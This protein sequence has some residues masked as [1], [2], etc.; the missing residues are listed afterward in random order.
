MSRAREP[1]I[2]PAVNRTSGE[3]AVM[4]SAGGLRVPLRF[5]YPDNSPASLLAWYRRTETCPD[6]RHAW[7]ALMARAPAD[8]ETA[9][10]LGPD[11]Y[12][13]WFRFRLNLTCTR[14]GVVERLAGYLDDRATKGGKVDPVPI[15]AGALRAQ[16]IEDEGH[17]LPRCT[18]HE[19]LDPVPIGVISAAVTQRGRHYFAGRLDAWPQG[20]VVEAP[21]ITGCLRKLAAEPAMASTAGWSP[22]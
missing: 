15:R 17:V 5:A 3:A 11:E 14:C 1:M 2:L 20:R 6:G 19:G 9:S 10:V 13:E 12:P 22:S 8:A 16:N 7:D 18:V 21:S 4:W